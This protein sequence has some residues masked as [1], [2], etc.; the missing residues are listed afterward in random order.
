MNTHIHLYTQRLVTY[1]LTL[2]AKCCQNK[3]KQI[4]Q[5]QQQRDT[6]GTSV[7]LKKDPLPKFMVTFLPLPLKLTLQ[8]TKSQKQKLKFVHFTS[9]RVAFSSLEASFSQHLLLQQLI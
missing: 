1:E 7:L 6:A 5:T 9:I 8:F 4:D 2:I 3:H